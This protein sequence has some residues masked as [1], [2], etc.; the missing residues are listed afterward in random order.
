M[1][2]FHL[3]ELA[4]RY[5]QYDMI[6]LHTEVP[7]FPEGR[8]RLLLAF[9]KESGNPGK[10]AENLTLAVSLVQMGIDIHEMVSMSNQVKEKKA[11]RSRQLKVL[12]GDYFSSGYYHLLSEAGQIELVEHIAGSICEV[13]RLKMTLY[14]RIQQ[15]KLTADEYLQRK[16]GI[17]AQLFARFDHLMKSGLGKAWHDT[18]ESFSRCELLADE[19]DHCSSPDS[20]RES[21]A[22]WRIRDLGYTEALQQLESAGD[23]KEQAAGL[24]QKCRINE[25]LMQL[26]DEQ[27]GH[28]YEKARLLDSDRL[29]QELLQIGEPFLRLVRQPPAAGGAMR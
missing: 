9:L 3:P 4:K 14:A 10:A 7:A 26:L 27:V 11:V 29:M 15:M 16:T 5:T 23:K 2:S 19:L 24:L 22:Y 1:N 28:L 25:Q 20:F 21:W 18:L 12:A 13:N 17:R 8:S 6:R